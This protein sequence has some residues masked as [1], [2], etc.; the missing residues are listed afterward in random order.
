MVQSL[1]LPPLS[2]LDYIFNE[3]SPELII[4]PMKQKMNRTGK[5]S[6][7]YP[8][9]CRTRHFLFA[10]LSSS[11]GSLRFFFLL[12]KVSEKEKR[13]EKCSCMGEES[14]V[15]MVKMGLDRIFPH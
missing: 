13:K 12:L 15:N 7:A 1:F 8:E 3:Y 2:L 14:F 5:R 9:D 6:S 4:F 11:P 10:L